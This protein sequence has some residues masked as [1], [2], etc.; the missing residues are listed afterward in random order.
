MDVFYFIITFLVWILVF[1]SLFTY[2]RI[3]KLAQE[4]EDHSL[5]TNQTQEEFKPVFSELIN[6]DA[7][8][9]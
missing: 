9:P 3:L 8:A 1:H 4:N 7:E 5:I 6:K 2:P